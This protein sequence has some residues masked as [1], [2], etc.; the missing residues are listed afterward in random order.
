MI[1]NMHIAPEWK[2]FML[3]RYGRPDPKGRYA[4]I[5]GRRTQPK[6]IGI[7]GVTGQP[8][9]VDGKAGWCPVC[10]RGVLNVI[11]SILRQD[12]QKVEPVAFT[13]LRSLYVLVADSCRDS[14][15]AS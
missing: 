3:H 6:F 10:A 2:Q 1:T 9:V 4:T 13:H 11:V 8:A 5:C 12:I 15:E 14:L 7:P